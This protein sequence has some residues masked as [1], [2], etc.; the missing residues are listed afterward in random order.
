MKRFIH[1]SSS[2]MLV[3]FLC[4]ASVDSVQVVDET[5]YI[6]PTCDSLG[7]PLF[8]DGIQV[9]VSPLRHPVPVI[10]GF[11]E[12]GYAPP[13]IEDDY[14]KAKLNQAIKKVYVPIG[15]TVNVL[16]TFDYE[17]TQFKAIRTENKITQYIGFLMTIITVYL[18]LHIT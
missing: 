9:G 7:I 15:D 17:Y 2:L 8:I 5:G 11:H 12:I 13:E 18:L 1:C 14:V 3:T 4:S 16:L 10:A 6:R